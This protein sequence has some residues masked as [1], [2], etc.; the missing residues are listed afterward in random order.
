MTEVMLHLR[1]HKPARYFRSHEAMKQLPE[2][3]YASH[4]QYHFEFV[5]RDVIGRGS[6]II[7]I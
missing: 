6:G 3:S 1:L 7:A 4:A 5:P 2:A